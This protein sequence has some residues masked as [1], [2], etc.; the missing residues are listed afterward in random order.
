MF[1]R[2][3]ELKAAGSDPDNHI[4]FLSFLLKKTHFSAL[5]STGAGPNTI[6]YMK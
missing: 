6:N 1:A 4:I 2:L 5:E 3:L